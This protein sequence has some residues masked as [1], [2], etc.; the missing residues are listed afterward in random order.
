ML[1]VSIRL[2]LMASCVLGTLTCN[3][4]LVEENLDQNLY[5]VIDTKYRIYA[6]VDSVYPT[7]GAVGR[8]YY[9]MELTKGQEQ[10]LLNRTVS[11]LEV[12]TG[13]SLSG[14][15]FSELWT[16]YKGNQFAERI[17]GNTKYL[18]LSFPINQKRKWDGNQYNLRSS[19]FYK[20]QTLDTLLTLNAN[21]FPKSVMVL[22]ALDTTSII[23]RRYA[24]EIYAPGIGKVA[25][26]DQ[27]IKRIITGTNVEISSESYFHQETLISHNYD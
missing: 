12:Y 5:P 17:E 26:Y 23:T 27:H 2:M 10:D 1:K 20:Y 4:K 6:V 24:W 13:D 19:E 22:Q 7:T 25:K 21:T 14:L 3:R 9:K 11:R 16:Q 8:K 18:V 15:T